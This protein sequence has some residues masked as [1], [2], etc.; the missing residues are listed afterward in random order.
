M[1]TVMIVDDDDFLHKIF[2]RILTLDGHEVVAQAYD[3]QEAIDIYS[4][5][6][7]KPDIILMDQRMPVMNGI[8][9]TSALLKIDPD[10]LIVFVSADESVTEETTAAGASG[11]LVKPIREAQLRAAIR[12]HIEDKQRKT[13]VKAKAENRSP[14]P[15]ESKKQRD[16]QE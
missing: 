1:A 11:F 2:K 13:S 8:E 16:G 4:K 15:H 12:V 14:M 3:G 7:V 9:S 6:D 10:A 5:L